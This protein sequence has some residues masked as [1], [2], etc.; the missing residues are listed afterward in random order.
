MISLRTSYF[1]LVLTCAVLPLAVAAHDPVV[2]MWSVA[3]LI[4]AGQL[5]R[6]V[7]AQAREVARRDSPRRDSPRRRDS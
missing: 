1:L 2:L 3:S 7:G 5:V 4:L 6:E